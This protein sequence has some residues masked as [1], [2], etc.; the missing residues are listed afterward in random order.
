M[1]EEGQTVPDRGK[2][3]WQGL[4][5]QL[6]GEVEIVQEGGY[7]AKRGDVMLGLDIQ[8]AGNTAHVAGTL[9][10]WGGPV[11]GSWAGEIFVDVP[12]VSGYFCFREGPPLLALIARLQEEGLPAPQLLLVDG[13]GLAHPRRFG[14]ACWV[15]LATG[16]PTLGAAKDTLLR[17][18][19]ELDEAQGSTVSVCLA[20]DEVGVVLRRRKGIRPVYVSPGH[21][22][23]LA[24]ATRVVTGLPSKFRIPDILRF[25]DQAARAHCKGKHNERWHD[26]GTLQPVSPPWES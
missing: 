23:S 12:Y 21:R 11:L 25:P 4:Q 7:E 3:H 15:G 9:A 22:I 18:E 10:R 5:E 17:F 16:L 6:A 14:A 26:L 1:Q 2:E 19:G 20:E 13:H 8:Y 24:E